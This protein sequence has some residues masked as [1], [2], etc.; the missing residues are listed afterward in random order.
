MI[1][2]LKHGMKE[3]SYVFRVTCSKNLLKL[4]SYILLVVDPC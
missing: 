4:V 3:A 2:G 1:F